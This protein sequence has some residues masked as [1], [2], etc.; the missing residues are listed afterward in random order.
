MDTFT[1]RLA[2]RLAAQEIIKANSAAEV[3]KMQ[4][5][6][7]EVRDYQ[8]CVTQ[9]RIMN[10]EMQR[11]VDRLA[12]IVGDISEGGAGQ[13]QT[14]IQQKLQ[15]TV[16]EVLAMQTQTV[17]MHLDSTV[18][19]KLEKLTTELK[20][21]LDDRLTGTIETLLG[22]KLSG[23]IEALL[24][25][26][27]SKK[28][29]TLLGEK[30]SGEIETLLGDKLAGEIET[31]LG[32]KLSGEIETLLGDKLSKEIE[33]LL[34]DKLSKEIEALL[35]EKLGT[36]LGNQLSGKIDAILPQLEKAASSHEN[37]E[38]HKAQMQAWME[39][40]TAK[41]E[42]LSQNEALQE[43]RKRFLTDMQEHM[44]EHVHKENVKVYRN[45]QAVIME[46]SAKQAETIADIMKKVRSRLG[47]AVGMSITAMVLSALSVGGIAYL[48]LSELGFLP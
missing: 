32:D 46:E 29:E 33:I 4:K 25:D 48:L 30:L 15:R 39:E 21:S 47:L 17:A 23:E 27:L 45:V 36:Q 8:E 11:E 42:G 43:K 41:M 2:Q 31:L 13:S 12:G 19:R 1:D 22:E 44:E 28:I 20:S 34:G 35:T 6:Q 40:L 3:E 37:D 7:G 38:D 18:N 5:L 10:G 14:E 16:E 24:G 9:M 26:T